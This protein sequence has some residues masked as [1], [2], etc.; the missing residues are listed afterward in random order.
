MNNFYESL[1]YKKSVKPVESVVIGCNPVTLKVIFQ[2]G[3]IAFHR[4]S[5]GL[6]HFMVIAQFYEIE[7]NDFELHLCTPSPVGFHNIFGFVVGDKA[8]FYSEENQFIICF[9]SC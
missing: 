4:V 3:S 7:K 2:D 9:S 1:I 8:K 6:R 5:K